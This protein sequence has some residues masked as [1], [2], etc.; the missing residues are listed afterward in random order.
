MSLSH[1]LLGPLAD[2]RT[3]ALVLDR[4]ILEQNIGRMQ[5]RAENLGVAL[6]PHMKTAKCSEVGILATQGSKTRI[7]V[8]TIAEYAFFA[9]KGFSDILYAVPIVPEKIDALAAISPNTRP[10]IV[11]EDPEVTQNVVLRAEAIGAELDVMIEIDCDGHRGGRTADDPAIIV[12]AKTLQASKNARF[13]G[14]LVH[15]GGAYNAET[16]HAAQLAAHEE[17]DTAVRARAHLKKHGLDCS[18]V[19]IGSSPTAT[20]AGDLNGIDELRPGVYMFNDLFQT[21]LGICRLQDVALSVLATVVSH[22]PATG[23]IFVDAGA[24]ALSKDREVPNPGRSRGYG[25]VCSADDCKPIG[26]LI[27][28]DVYQEHGVVTSM[29]GKLDFETLPIGSKVRILPNH[30][31]LT[32]AAHEKYYVVNGSPNVSEVWDKCSGWY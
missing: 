1:D 15:A 28:S 16:T 6:R 10:S 26:D 2:V 27:V 11:I 24:L 19:S 18:L 17:R 32:A 4:Q 29:K 9:N 8:S 7:A 14:L 12:I 21:G 25:M 13:R 20:L 22:K 31:C 30:A 3:P 23:R 5:K